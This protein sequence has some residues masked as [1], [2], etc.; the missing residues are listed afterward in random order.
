MVRLY[1][2]LT[3]R[4]E[5]KAS[6]YSE[7]L[8][9]RNSM[10]LDVDELCNSLLAGMASVLASSSAVSPNSAIIIGLVGGML[11]QL[12]RWVLLRAELDDP[13]ETISVFGLPSVWSLLTVGIFDLNSGFIVVGVSQQLGIQL[14]GVAAHALWTSLIITIFFASLKRNHR[15]RAGLVYEVCGLDFLPSRWG[16]EINMEKVRQEQRRKVLERV[17]RREA[18][19]EELRLA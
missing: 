6:L 9:L 3:L 8:H 1:S 18:L 16:E 19:A 7:G 15:H 5:D 11:Y 4:E 14:L 17:L 10:V 13:V 12:M 2:N